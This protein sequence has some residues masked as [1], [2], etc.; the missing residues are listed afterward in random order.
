LSAEEWGLPA[1]SA[2]PASHIE[3]NGEGAPA[4]NG[5]PEF[6]TPS[7]NF[8]RPSDNLANLTDLTGTEHT[9]LQEC[10]GGDPLEAPTAPLQD[11]RPTLQ[12]DR[13]REARR[14]RNREELQRWEQEQRLRQF[15]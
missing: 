15:T 11:A 4:D 6:R 2:L 7:D 14:V 5:R 10:K 8:S 13:I 1:L 3:I 9:T 12:G